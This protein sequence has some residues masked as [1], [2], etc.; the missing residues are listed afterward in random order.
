M[1]EIKRIL[2]ANR[3]EIAFR[4]MRTVQKMRLVP[5][6]VYSDADAQAWPRFPGRG[7]YRLGP[8]PARDSYLS[9]E[10][11]LRV[12]REARADAIH[13]GYGFLSENADFA[14]A[15]AAAGIT[16]IGP[17]AAAI[18]AM[19]SKS[20]AKAL[21]ETAG[22]PLVPGYHGDD[23]SDVALAAAAEQIGY[24]VL[25]KA[26]A[27]GGGRGM[28]IVREPGALA[29]ALASAR[30]EAQGAFGD[31]RLLLERYLEHARHVEVQ[32]FGDEHGNLV[33]MFE[34]DCSV[35]RRYQK[36]MEEAPAPGLSDGLRA[37]LH[38]AALKAAR[39]VGYVSAGTVEFIVAGDHAYFMEMNTRL[40]V[41]HPVTES[42][43]GLDLVEWQIRVAR[44]EP[45]PLAQERITC[46]GH[47]IE[48]RLY[49]EDPQRDFLPQSGPLDRFDLPRDRTTRVDAGYHPGMTVPPYYDALLAKLISH[50]DDR[51]GAIASL[52]DAVSQLRV[53]GIV[54]NKR[55]LA[56][57]LKHQ[58]FAQN[59]HD[60]SFI[61]RE[62]AELVPPR[63]RP[64]DAMAAFAAMYLHGAR[65]D[66]LP[67]DVAR[68]T[69]VPG[70]DLRWSPWLLHDNWQA[71]LPAT[72]VTHLGDGFGK[73]TVTLAVNR[74]DGRD[75]RFA[76]TV[77]VGGTAYDATFCLDDIDG[78]NLPASG[79]V[80]DVDLWGLCVHQG[81]RITILGRDE[82]AAFH[83]L[84]P[85]AAPTGTA[86]G[87]GQLVA[88]MPGTV[89]AVAV[90]TGQQVTAGQTLVVVEAM[91]MEHAVKA[92]HDGTVSRVDCSVGDLVREG[93]ELVVLE[94]S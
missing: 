18:R 86:A 27:G 72:T 20:A 5:I 73:R 55:F 49:A 12:A 46:S 48:A 41:E 42:V 52:T 75:G 24:P 16:F 15:C 1:R 22:V 65:R 62:I 21:M 37:R 40:Q 43:T 31:D 91:K 4:I 9:V 57:I 77:T 36:V 92:P 8:A 70:S 85:R 64:G 56:A 17:P 10:A 76:G 14:D 2:V 34:R 79:K 83:I 84:D 33:H 11:V 3:G 6:S 78:E 59:R 80:G 44:G 63:Q 69:L 82:E 28:R 68:A 32:V 88:P 67:A 61:E 47:A 89:A 30:R 25:V 93:Q 71:N 66:L 54:T 45:L 90:T 58:G 94:A 39:A 74:S 51:L 13:P 38:E 50:A 7:A 87:G 81:D 60:T 35:Q 19:G 53:A 26:S 23:Q 29:E